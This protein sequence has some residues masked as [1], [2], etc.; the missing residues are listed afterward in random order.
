[1]L[2]VV[3]LFKVNQFG[4]TTVNKTL[5]NEGTPKVIKETKKFDF[6]EKHE[7]PSEEEFKAS[8]M[9]KKEYENYAQVYYR[10]HLKKDFNLF[11]LRNLIYSY[12]FTRQRNGK[13]LLNIV[14]SNFEVIWF[15]IRREVMRKRISRLMS[16]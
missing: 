2:K 8:Q 5:K 15:I 12:I 10:Y 3:R 11:D 14:D 7:L 16:S 1:M 9:P 4:F 13:I 6:K